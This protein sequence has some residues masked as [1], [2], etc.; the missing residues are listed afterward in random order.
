[1]D[2]KPKAAMVSNDHGE[3]PLHL[4]SMFQPMEVVQCL[5]RES[6]TSVFVHDQ[7]G[8]LPLHSACAQ[9]KSIEVIQLLVEACPIALMCKNENKKTPLHITCQDHAS[10]CVIEYLVQKNWDILGWQDQD[11]NLPLHYIF[12]TFHVNEMVPLM[13]LH[14][15]LLAQLI[16]V[17][18]KRGKTPGQDN[19]DQWFQNFTKQT[20]KRLAEE[21]RIRETLDWMNTI[22]EAMN[23]SKAFPSSQIV[24]KWTKNQK[25]KCLKTLAWMELELNHLAEKYTPQEQRMRERMYDQWYNQMLQIPYPW[26]DYVDYSSD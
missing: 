26:H 14:M 9:C 21:Q 24:L 11:G 15:P 13:R 16:Q 22:I 12:E 8:N 25:E 3:L 19:K 4:A 10:V 1:L 6:P 23:R 2:A 20:T 18:N 17:K 5:I 7:C